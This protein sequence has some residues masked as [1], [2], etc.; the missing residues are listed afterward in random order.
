MQVFVMILVSH[1]VLYKEKVGMLKNPGIS[2]IKHSICCHKESNKICK[3][4]ADSDSQKQISIKKNSKNGKSIEY[5]H[6]MIGWFHNKYFLAYKIIFLHE[7]WL[8]GN[9]FWVFYAKL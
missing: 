8:K 9:I 1:T 3:L 2:S 6:E 5:D 7:K 4:S